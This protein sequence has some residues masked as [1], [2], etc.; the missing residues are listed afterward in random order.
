MRKEN[1]YGTCEYAGCEEQASTI[2]YPEPRLPEIQYCYPHYEE[3]VYGV[4]PDEWPS[5]TK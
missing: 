5:E 3:I 1:K 4:L 2:H